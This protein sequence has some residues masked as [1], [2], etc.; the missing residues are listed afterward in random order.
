M[1][2]SYLIFSPVCMWSCWELEGA[3]GEVESSER[4][5]VRGPPNTQNKGLKGLFKVKRISAFDNP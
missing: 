4:A 3:V 1:P 2:S 5:D